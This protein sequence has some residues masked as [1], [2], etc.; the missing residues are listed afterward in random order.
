MFYFKEKDKG[1]KFL[2]PLN[3]IDCDNARVFMRF[4]KLFYNATLRFLGS[5]HITSDVFFNELVL[6][7]SKLI[8]L[9]KTKNHLLSSMAESTKVKYDKY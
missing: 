2:R 1:I 9:S 7:Q 3:D 4:L 5:S 6:I 8:H